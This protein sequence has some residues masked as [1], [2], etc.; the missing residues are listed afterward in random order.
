MLP[1]REIDLG[2]VLL[3][4]KSINDYTG[5][6]GLKESHYKQD[7]YVY[8]N[9]KKLLQRGKAGWYE[10]GL[11]QKEGNLPLG[12]NK[13]GSLGR[14]KSLVRNLKQDSKIHKPYDTVI[15]EQVQNKIIKRSSNNE[16]SNC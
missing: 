12:N 6:L 2:S 9:F 7:Y 11:V 15:Q 5:V 16:I 3:N 14:L 1:G 8:E 10:P 13:N 4:K